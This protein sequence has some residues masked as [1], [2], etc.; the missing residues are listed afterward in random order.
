[1][2]LHNKFW[3]W[4]P[5]SV[6]QTGIF[7]RYKNTTHSFSIWN[8]NNSLRTRRLTL[9]VRAWLGLC[10]HVICQIQ[11][12][13]GY[14]ITCPHIFVCVCVCYIWDSTFMQISINTWHKVLK[15]EKHNLSVI[16]INLSSFQKISTT[17]HWLC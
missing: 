10:E 17:K 16:A 6:I 8:E 9:G 3:L 5:N 4:L 1:M 14:S 12:R 2:N 15:S 13:V 11:E 7:F